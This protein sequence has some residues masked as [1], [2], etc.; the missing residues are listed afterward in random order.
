MSGS[1]KEHDRWHDNM[2]C[3]DIQGTIEYMNTVKKPWIGFKVLAAGA[4]HPR[5][6]FK[7]ALESGADFI[8][9]GMFDFQIREDVIIAK[10]TL[11][12]D[13]NRQRP[14]RA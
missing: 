5:K 1:K 12:G 6:A 9:A 4:I 14:W 11:S 7:F 13:L 2:Y 8:C 3:R 10:D